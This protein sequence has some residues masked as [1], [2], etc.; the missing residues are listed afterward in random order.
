MKISNRV[1]SLPPS[2]IRKMFEIASQYDDII[3]LCIGEPDF[4][5][6]HHIVEAGCY[7]L[8]NGYTKYVA[9]AGLPDL[10][11]AVAKKSV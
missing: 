2:G 7:G 11:A 9:N 10:R 6:P 8:N 4:E 1:S 3:N 5:T